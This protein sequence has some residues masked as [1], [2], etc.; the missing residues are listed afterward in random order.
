VKS[1]WI[2]RLLSL[3]MA[4][5]IATVIVCWSRADGVDP[6]ATARQSAIVNDFNDLCS[7]LERLSASLAESEPEKAELCRDVL[8]TIRTRMISDRMKAAAEDMRANRS[9]NALTDVQEAIPLLIEILAMLEGGGDFTKRLSALR[10]IIPRIEE[11]LARMKNL[12]TAYE[13][14]TPDAVESVA[15]DQRTLSADTARIATDCEDN[16][17]P[18]TAAKLKDSSAKMSAASEAMLGRHTDDA[19][20][21]QAEALESLK[22]ALDSAR[23]TAGVLDA[24]QKMKRA[25]EIKKELEAVIAAQKAILETTK[26]V[27][28]GVEAEG[29]RLTRALRLRLDSA[30]TEQGKLLVQYSAVEKAVGD[31]DDYGVFIYLIGRASANAKRASVALTS[32]K[33]GA[34]AQEP[35]EEALKAL[36]A[37]LAGLD[38]LSRE[39]QE[40]GDASGAGGSGGKKGAILPLAQV[41]AL[42]MEQEDIADRTARLLDREPAKVSREEL[43]DVAQRQRTCADLFKKLVE[44][45]AK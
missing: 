45:A 15:R 37:M 16:S 44:E 43:S 19:K 3:L 25:R 41:V 38:E 31:D 17:F 10:G 26:A 21:R 12:M 40:D 42:K 20:S 6:E 9:N 13:R 11:L 7:K 32:E 23:K 33:C 28:T 36:Q 30:A 39:P 1:R 5:A 35:Q 34:E 27:S 22:A 18:D 8:K 14:T 29:G 24:L 4:F 2:S